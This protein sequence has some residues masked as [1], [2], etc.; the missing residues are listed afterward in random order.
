MMAGVLCLFTVGF[1]CLAPR[2]RKIK[3]PQGMNLG[4]LKDVKQLAP[5]V[6]L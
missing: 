5:A 1:G 3:A 6:A 4:E 2:R